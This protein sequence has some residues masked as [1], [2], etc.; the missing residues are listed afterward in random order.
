MKYIELL[1]VFLILILSILVRALTMTLGLISNI[2]LVF[3]KLFR[4]LKQTINH[5]IL[6]IK[7]EVKN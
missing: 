7:Y 1:K 3:E 4:V 6:Q 2:M 5:L